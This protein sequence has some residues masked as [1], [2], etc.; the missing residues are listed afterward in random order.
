MATQE[1]RLLLKGLFAGAPGI[2]QCLAGQV[3]VLDKQ[4]A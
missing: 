4:H 2:T 3:Q 1:S